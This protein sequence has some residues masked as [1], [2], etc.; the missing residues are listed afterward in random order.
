MTC[1]HGQGG[2][3]TVEH[4]FGRNMTRCASPSPKQWQW[5]SDLYARRFE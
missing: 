3:T 1:A 2:L 4:D 5:L